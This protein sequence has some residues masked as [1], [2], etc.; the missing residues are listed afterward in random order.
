MTTETKEITNSDDVIDVRDVIARV[1]QLES[2]LEDAQPMDDNEQV[3]SADGSEDLTEQSEELRLLTALL[4]DL[5]GNGGDED[6]RDAW[7]PVTL[8]RSAYFEDYAQ[9]LAE[10]LGAINRDAAWPNNHINWEEAAAELSTDYSNV[11]FDGVEYL[12]R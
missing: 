2:E 5:A 8:I 9:E 3:L 7:Y 6:W 4:E 1:E 11:E 12:Y 10:D